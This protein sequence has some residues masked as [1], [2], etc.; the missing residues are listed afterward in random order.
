MEGQDQNESKTGIDD[1]WTL[2]S[3][4][5]EMRNIKARIRRTPSNSAKIYAEAFKLQEI[6]ALIAQWKANGWV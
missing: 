4:M 6:E 5:R 3:L 1:N 2:D